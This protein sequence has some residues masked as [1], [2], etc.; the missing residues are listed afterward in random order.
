MRAIVSE[1]GLNQL[2]MVTK[3]QRSAT[4]KRQE[5]SGKNWKF[6]NNDCVLE[7]RQMKDNSVGLVVT[8]I[9]F[10]NHYEYTPS[11]LDFGHTDNDNHFFAQMDHL[12]PELL[13]VVKPGRIACI[14]VKDRIFY[15]SQTGTGFSTVNPFHALIS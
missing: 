2:A 10:S 14:H 5:A 1:H 15:G 13:R 6:I 11:Y 7:T 3:L 8:S 9:P 4:V 12:I